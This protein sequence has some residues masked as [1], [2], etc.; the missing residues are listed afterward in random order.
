MK[1]EQ[2]FEELSTKSYL[3]WKNLDYL[4]KCWN[5]KLST[6][7][8]GYGSIRMSGTSILAHRAAYVL[9]GKK[10]DLMQCVCHSCDNPKCCNPSHLFVGSHADNMKD[11]ALKNRRKNINTKEKNGRAKLSEQD[12]VK[13]RL[14]RVDMKLIEL[15]KMFNVSNSTISRVCRMENWK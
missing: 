12:A 15:S 14:L 3:L 2:A 9:S 6:N 10:L 1:Q 13:I 11:M 7:K 5:W 8:S 4:D